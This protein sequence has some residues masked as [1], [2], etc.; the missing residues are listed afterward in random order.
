MIFIGYENNGYCFVYYTQEN[1]ILHS[2]HAIFD[3]KLFPR[4][5]NFHV[6]EYKL[7]NKLL[8]RISPETKSSV[9]DS[10]EKGRLAPIPI[11]HTLIPLI[12]KNPFTHSSSSSLSYK[13]IF[14]SST[15]ESKKPS[16]DWR[17]WWC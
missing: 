5:T 17:E 4:Y 10:S 1:I 6:K 15:P 9:S 16:K 8:D 11:P 3:E 2:I 12:Q 14:L 13:S 7:Y